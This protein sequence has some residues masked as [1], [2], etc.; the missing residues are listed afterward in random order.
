[1]SSTNTAP[2]DS[3]KP[4][5]CGACGKPTHTEIADGW[6]SDLNAYVGCEC[7]VRGPEITLEG[8][9]RRAEI[10]TLAVAAWNAM[11]APWAGEATKHLA[12]VVA[13][14]QRSKA[15]RIG[16]HFM[17]VMADEVADAALAELGLAGGEGR[18]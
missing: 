1:M 15:G 17:V 12:K 6:G 14:H 13:D 18:G 11:W 9:T 16:G 3:T 2:A 8:K 7:G 10:E 5:A 4:A